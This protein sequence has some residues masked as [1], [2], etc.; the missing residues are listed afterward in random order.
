MASPETVLPHCDGL[1]LR[2]IQHH[3][4]WG[5]GLAFSLDTTAARR[6][7]LSR[8]RLFCALLIFWRVASDIFLPLFHGL[9][10]CSLGMPCGCAAST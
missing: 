7:W 10:P 1:T 8:Q 3:R 5:E 6:P 4:D 9:R 2:L